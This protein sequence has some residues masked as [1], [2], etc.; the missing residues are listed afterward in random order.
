VQSRDPW[1]E[2]QIIAGSRIEPRILT[3]RLSDTLTRMSWIL[4]VPLLLFAGVVALLPLAA[5]VRPPTSTPR[6]TAKAFIITLAVI[7]LS[8]LV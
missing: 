3:A 5:L 2:G 4:P 8:R 1:R 7:A 6:L